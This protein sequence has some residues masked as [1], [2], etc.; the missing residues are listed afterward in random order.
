[1]SNINKRGLAG[2]QSFKAKDIDINADQIEIAP[3]N[4]QH[5]YPVIIDAKNK[6]I[7]SDMD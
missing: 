5:E 2:L 6:S 3:A 1:M 4:V 7:L